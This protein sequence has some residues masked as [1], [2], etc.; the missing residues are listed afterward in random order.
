MAERQ[1]ESDPWLIKSVLVSAS[2]GE[3]PMNSNFNW[4]YNITLFTSFIY[5]D[6][7]NK[8]VIKLPQ[9]WATVDHKIGP[10]LH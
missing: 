3:I 5:Y 9:L 8:I 10:L 7:S 1:E 4:V 2:G 6:I